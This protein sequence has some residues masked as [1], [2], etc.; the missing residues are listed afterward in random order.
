MD[1][2]GRHGPALPG[3]GRC[4]TA[5]LVGQSLRQSQGNFTQLFL[6]RDPHLL[7]LTSRVASQKIFSLVLLTPALT[8][9]NRQ[10]ASQMTR[11]VD[12]PGPD[13]QIG[14]VNFANSGGTHLRSVTHNLIDTTTP[15]GK[16]LFGVFGLM[17]EFERDMLRQRTNARP[18]PVPDRAV[19]PIRPPRAC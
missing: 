10:Y 18:S 6:Y 4:R 19:F 17:A 15:S 14:V 11:S 7:T 3:A 8:Q 12:R 2:Y 13:H 9:I 5:F 16:P 1:A